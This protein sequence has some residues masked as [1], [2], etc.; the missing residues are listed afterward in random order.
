[1][2]TSTHHHDYGAA[3]NTNLHAINNSQL[4]DNAASERT[5]SQSNSDPDPESTDEREE[6]HEIKHFSL[7]KRGDCIDNFMTYNVAGF[8]HRLSY[9]EILQQQD[10]SREQLEI[11]AMMIQSAKNEGSNT[12]E[13]GSSSS[14]VE[15]QPIPGRGSLVQQVARR[16]ESYMRF[17]GVSDA[18]MPR[19]MD[20]IPT[21]LWFRAIRATVTH[22]TSSD[23]VNHMLDF[24]QEDI[25]P[26]TTDLND[27]NAL[28]NLWTQ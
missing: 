17:S 16:V 8:K 21:S 1:M 28:T 14:E 2:Q 19:I 3:F 25:P 12:T 24:M 5:M 4:H 18:M 22:I 23:P 11:T 6:E 27:H 26:A 9:E 15:S 20:T 10:D 7:D 13:E